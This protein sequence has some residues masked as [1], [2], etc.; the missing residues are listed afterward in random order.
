MS[1]IDSDVVDPIGLTPSANVFN[2]CCAE[3]L[4]RVGTHQKVGY[5]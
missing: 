4:G 5:D 3:I 1:I 2:G